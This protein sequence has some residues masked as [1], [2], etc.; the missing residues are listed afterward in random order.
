[1]TH[2][3]DNIQLYRKEVLILGLA[4]AL[5]SSAKMSI[6]G[7]PIMLIVLQYYFIEY[8]AVVILAFLF[9]HRCIIYIYIFINKLLSSARLYWLIWGK[10]NHSVVL[11]NC[12][13][14]VG[15]CICTWGGNR[16]WPGG[17][18]TSFYSGNVFQ[19]ITWYEICNRGGNG[20]W[21]RGH[22]I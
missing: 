10:R 3:L 5:S 16:N 17:H 1:M 9:F 20:K 22:E 6:T 7:H 12:P 14:I 11:K 15:Y 4:P 2:N 13:C 21:S 19:C 18:K 8:D